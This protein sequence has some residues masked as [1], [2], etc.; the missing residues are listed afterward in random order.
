[1]KLCLGTAQLG[2]NYGIANKSGKPSCFEATETVKTA[3]QNG[4]SFFD[5]AQAYGDS[6]LI[7]GKSF[8]K[9][10][11]NNSVHVISKL[12]PSMD[13]LDKDLVEMAVKT[14][15]NKLNIDTL[16]GFLLHRA[17]CLL[18][19][20]KGLRNIFKGLKTKGLIKYTGVSVYNYEEA[21]NALKLD[22]IDI[23]QLPLNVFDQFA[24]NKGILVKARERGKQVFLRSIYLQG[25]LTLNPDMLPGKLEFAKEP[26]DKY[27]G[28]CKKYN[29]DPIHI[30]ISFVKWLAGD[31]P[32]IIGAENHDQVIKNVNYFS[33]KLKNR[34]YLFN[35]LIDTFSESANPRLIN[36]G[37]W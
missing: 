3:W 7:L 32:I 27:H 21:S 19:W 34:E 11:I 37:L 17:G 35:E 4:I 31:F 23:I 24:V 20:Q 26:L 9:L 18:D 29:S 5:T 1:M 30:S 33:K 36:P 25:L 8:H 16:Y 10:G 12:D 14:S 2:M 13:H 15:L 22:D 6:E 28:I